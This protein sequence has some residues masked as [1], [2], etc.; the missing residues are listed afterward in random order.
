M[1]PGEPRKISFP[2]NHLGNGQIL[3]IW[4]SV[5]VPNPRE[6]W[7]LLSTWL[8]LFLVSTEAQM[9]FGMTFLESQEDSYSF[10]TEGF[11]FYLT[12]KWIFRYLRLIGLK[13]THYTNNPF[14]PNWAIFGIFWMNT[15]CFSEKENCNMLLGPGKY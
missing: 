12:I 15:V 7:L 10:F 11:Y 6:W 13:N 14:F 1:C 5:F 8:R 2:F 4:R 3:F 9:R